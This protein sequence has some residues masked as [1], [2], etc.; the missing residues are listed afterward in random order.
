MRRV[1]LV[2]TI[3]RFGCILVRYG[4]RHD[5]FRT[6]AAGFPSRPLDIARSGEHLARYVISMLEIAPDAFG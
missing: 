6:P 1:D 4:G 3:E 2:R 5:W